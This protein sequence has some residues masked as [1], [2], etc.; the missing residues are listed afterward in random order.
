MKTLPPKE[1]LISINSWWGRLGNHLIQ[2]SNA[3]NI[4]KKTHSKLIIPRHDI[5]KRTVFDFTRPGNNHYQEPVAGAFFF[6]SQ[7]FQYPLAYDHERRKVFQ[8]HVYDL[9]QARTLWEYM[10][11][12]ATQRFT[13]VGPD[14]LVIN[15]RSGKDIF[16]AEP[17][18]DTG[19]YVQPPLS[20]YKHIIETHHYADCLIVTEAD[21]KN[22]CIEALLSWNPRIRIKKHRSVKDDIRTILSAT[23]LVMCHSTFSWCL[24][25]MSKQ[26]RTLFQEDT[27][28]IKSVGDFST[29]TYGFE[30]YIKQGEWKCSPA[31]LEKMLTHSIA[32]LRVIHKPR[33][34]AA[35]MGDAEPSV[36]AVA[37]LE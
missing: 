20:Y 14:T 31:Q 11:S 6:Q 19:G 25:L 34:G 15:I 26:L 32:D 23:H 29:Y 13:L 18:P 36:C 37:P 33:T 5:I 28:P 4:A 16:C 10:L 21:R 2:L 17:A 35:S 8:E 24:A 22:P 9:L 27:F 7:C 1:Y 12:L 3:L 30:N